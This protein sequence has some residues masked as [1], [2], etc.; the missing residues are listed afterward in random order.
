VRR[1]LLEAN[2]KP[3]YVAYNFHPQS[4][5]TW[6]ILTYHDE[7]LQQILILTFGHITWIFGGYYAILGTWGTSPIRATCN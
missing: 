6:I 3:F 1:D 4:C 2:L 5:H 7:V